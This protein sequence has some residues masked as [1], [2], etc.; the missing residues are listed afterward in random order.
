MAQIRLKTCAQL[1]TELTAL[2]AR[3]DAVSHAINAVGNQ[4]EDISRRL[5]VLEHRADQQQHNIE[6]I[7][8]IHE[9]LGHNLRTLVQ[10]DTC[11]NK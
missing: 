11:A 8:R 9:E 7:Q 6:N 5:A 2:Q 3:V 1:L 10:S 4:N